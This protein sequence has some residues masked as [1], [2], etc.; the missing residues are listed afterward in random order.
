MYEEIIEQLKVNCDCISEDEWTDRSKLEANITEF[1][2]LISTMTCWKTKACENLLLSER[3]EIFDIDEMSRECNTCDNGLVVKQ[4][5]FDLIREESITVRIVVRE[6]IRIQEI[7]IPKELFSLNPYTDELYV[8][9]SDYIYE[10][11]ICSCEKII[12]MV[13]TYDAGYEVL[14]DCLFPILCDFLD[15]IIDMNKCTCGA[16]STCETDSTQDVVI[17]EGETDNSEFISVKLQIRNL[18][19]STYM[20][21]LEFI[22]LCGDSR[23]Y[24]PF[25][26]LVV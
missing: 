13:V 8:D 18:I 7:E 11:D 9:L 6:G 24:M 23:A 12:K 10:Y 21:Q 19:T 2:D 25:N 4:L 26:G 15:Y 3:Q 16:C 14:P 17:V 1:L 20:R 22:S 5:Y